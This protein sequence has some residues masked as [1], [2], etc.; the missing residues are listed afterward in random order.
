MRISII[1]IIVLACVQLSASSSL[2]TLIQRFER[3]DWG[4]QEIEV[5]LGSMYEQANNNYNYPEP[6]TNYPSNNGFVS[7]ESIRETTDYGYNASFGYNRVRES[8]KTCYDFSIKPRFM[9]T[10]SNWEYRNYTDE[11]G[12]TALDHENYERMDELGADIEFDSQQYIADDFFLSADT[13]LSGYSSNYKS[14]DDSGDI[15]EISGGYMDI[16]MRLGVGYGRVHD[17]TNLVRAKRMAG[18]L[19]NRHGIELSDEQILLLAQYLDSQT[20]YTSVFDWFDNASDSSFW[21]DA[22]SALGLQLTYDQFLDMTREAREGTLLRRRQGYSYEFG[23]LLG[24]EQSEREK[25]F[26]DSY[27]RDKENFESEMI[28]RGFYGEIG[29]WI[30][31]SVRD[32]I[33]FSFPVSLTLSNY[34]STRESDDNPKYDYDFDFILLSIT[35]GIAYLIQVTDRIGCELQANAQFHVFDRDVKYSYLSYDF[36]A[37][38]TS[39]LSESTR[40]VF[41]AGYERTNYYDHEAIENGGRVH[42]RWLMNLQVQWRPFSSMF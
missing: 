35:P 6:N 15:N 37:E 18:L 30:N 26:S 33:S 20:A 36:G 34:E 42:D 25:K 21:R 9:W 17:V 19:S 39:Y 27:S 31:T 14:Q 38:L 4:Y 7:D 41:N 22:M 29:Y 10:R 16:D 23:I 3:G 24:H 8:E 12:N 40:L 13:E 2:P 28:R 1:S 11:N 32:Q 5:N